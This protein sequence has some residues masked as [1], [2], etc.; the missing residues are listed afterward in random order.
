MGGGRAIRQLV[1]RV[2]YEWSKKLL[3]VVKSH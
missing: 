2:N 1:V 3:E